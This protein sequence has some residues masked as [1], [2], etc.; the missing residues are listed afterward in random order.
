[1]GTGCCLSARVIILPHDCT[2]S[3]LRLFSGSYCSMMVDIES[4]VILVCTLAFCAGSNAIHGTPERAALAARRTQVTASS[5]HNILSYD[6]RALRGSVI[7]AKV[8][9]YSR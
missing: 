8:G 7:S 5:V 2:G 6:S 1:M 9:M 4:G 3:H